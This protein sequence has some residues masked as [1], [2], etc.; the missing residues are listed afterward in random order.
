MDVKDRAF[1]VY[2]S[3]YPVL[4]A[5]VGVATLIGIL[6]TFSPQLLNRLR[7]GAIVF[8]YK[9]VFVPLNIFTGLLFLFLLANSTMM[10]AM[11]PAV[12]ET[13]ALITVLYD[14][15]SLNRPII[16]ELITPL[17]LELGVSRKQIS[18]LP[19]NDVNLVSGF[20]TSTY[21]LILAHGVDGQLYTTNPLK[22]YSHE[23]IDRLSKKSL[24]LVYYSSCHLGIH[25]ND[26][27]WVKASHPAKAILYTRESAIL[28][29]IVW[30]IFKARTEI[31]K[32]EM[33]SSSNC[34][35]PTSRHV[36]ICA[37]RFASYAQTT[38][39]SRRRLSVYYREN[40]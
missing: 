10:L 15:G 40:R 16:R 31:P 9:R 12:S 35:D 32:S 8:R 1:Y 36:T 26:K 37:G 7:I 13:P 6:I 5:I 3:I 18:I 33:A 11:T 27:L 23:M 19:I 17:V 39:G 38:P 4:L 21:L 34:F 28:E 24:K 20:G 22:A 2:S 25:G 30:L 29:H 14:A